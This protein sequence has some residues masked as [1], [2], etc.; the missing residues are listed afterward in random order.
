MTWHVLAIQAQRHRRVREKLDELGVTHYYPMRTIWRT[1]RRG[2]RKRVD[3]PLIPAYL[4]VDC[5]LTRRSARSILSI[6]GIRCFLG[7]AGVPGEV[8]SAELTRLRDA[9]LRGDHDE[10]AR[11][12]AK[13][14][15]GDMVSIYDGA[16]TGF[17]GPIVAIN[18]ERVSLDIELFGR[19]NTMT[20]DI[21]KLD[22]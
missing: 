8:D 10:T 18:G 2:P 13:L 9:V 19:S 14:N 7:V 15:I 16:Y 5:D 12:L 22:H 21:D 6:D 3:L 20:I 4:F 17:T 1:Q 11:R